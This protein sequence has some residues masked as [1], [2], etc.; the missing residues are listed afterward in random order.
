MSAIYEKRMDIR[1]TRTQHVITA[2]YGM[3]A[4]ELQEAVAHV[5]G[6]ANLIG[7]ELDDEDERVFKLVFE[8]E[9]ESEEKVKP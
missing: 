1:V 7:I 9:S 4:R 8:S 2:W 6:D 3:S 5:P